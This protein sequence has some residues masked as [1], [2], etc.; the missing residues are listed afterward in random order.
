MATDAKS[1]MTTAELLHFYVGMRL[2]KGDRQVPIQEILAD[3][4]EYMRQRERMRDMIRVADESLESGRSEP[5][6][7]EQAI[8]EV[9]REL[10]AEGITE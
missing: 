3:F 9:V 7:L 8:Q 1:E 6:D 10:A 5:F 2:E 4:P